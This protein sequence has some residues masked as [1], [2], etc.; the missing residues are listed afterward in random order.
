MKAE[1]FLEFKRQCSTLINDQA[2][3]KQAFNL[4]LSVAFDECAL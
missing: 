3:R 4:H 1:T 2:D